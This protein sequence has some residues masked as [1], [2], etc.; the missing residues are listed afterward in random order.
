M[1][2]SASTNF[3]LESNRI[4]VLASSGVYEPADLNLKESYNWMLGYL[5]SLVRDWFSHIRE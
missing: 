4:N 3:L 2:H 1:K 5:E